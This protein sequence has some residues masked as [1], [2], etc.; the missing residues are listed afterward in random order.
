MRAMGTNRAIKQQT[1]EG[2]NSTSVLCLEE[3]NYTIIS[4]SNVKSQTLGDSK[5]HES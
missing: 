4:F 3:T 5:V 2:L 1:W